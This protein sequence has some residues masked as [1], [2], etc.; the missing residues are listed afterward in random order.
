M[1]YGIKL[2][3][4]NVELFEEAKRL[5]DIKD[6]DFVELLFIPGKDTK[7]LDGSI[8]IIVHSPHFG[9]G[10]S[11][12]GPDLEK[13][14]KILRQTI[15]Y[16]KKMNAPYVIIHPEVGK[17][18][19]FSRLLKNLDK[20]DTNM[21]LIENMPCKGYGGV[22][23]IGFQP[24]ELREYLSIGN[25]GFCFDISH[26]IK[27][28]ITMKTDVDKYLD[29]LGK[30]GPKVVHISDGRLNNDSDEHLDIGKGDYDFKTIKKR[31]ENMHAEYLT[32]EVPK[33][34]LLDNDLKNIKRFR[35]I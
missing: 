10:V 26:A 29:T 28:A 12:G 14:I 32:F 3:S 13:N 16:A 34:K 6:I 33:T 30:L 15:G 24:D 1:K 5:H 17:K 7:S 4:S 8:P 2:W 22:D 20:K 19:N 11:Y 18:E 31:I 9:H 25:F 35:S 23:M 21:I 27:A